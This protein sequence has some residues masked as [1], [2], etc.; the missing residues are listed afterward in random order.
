MASRQDYCTLL[1][2]VEQV[3]GTKEDGLHSEPPD[4]LH[5]KRGVLTSSPNGVRTCSDAA[6]EDQLIGSQ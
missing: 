3:D 4:H 2:H 6:A 1:S 5:E